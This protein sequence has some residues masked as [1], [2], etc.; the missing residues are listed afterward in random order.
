MNMKYNTVDNGAAKRQGLSRQRPLARAI[1]PR[2][3]APLGSALCA[4]LLMAGCAVT[5]E[6]MTDAEIREQATKDLANMFPPQEIIDEALD[7]EE[8]VARAIRYNL[9]YRLTLMESALRNRQLDLVRYDMLPR[10]A[11]NAGWTNRTEDYLT[12]SR[13][14]VT[15]TVSPAPSESLDRN[16]R[17]ADLGLS[18]N[19]LDFGV[20]YYQAQQNADKVLI[21]QE[22]RRKVINQIV[23][24][25]RAAFWRAATAESLMKEVSPLLDEVKSAQRDARK[26]EERRLSP[27][28]EILRYQKS[29]AGLTREFEAIEQDM[30]MA[31]TELAALMGLPPGTDFELSVP[32]ADEL[33]PPQVGLAIEEMESLALFNR[34]EIREEMYQSRITA[35]EAKKAMLKM[36]PGITFTTSANYDSNS[37]LV[38]NDWAEAGM[39]VSW[40]LLN[41]IS[42]PASKRMV[43]A[44]QQ[45]DE[46]RRLAL[47]IATLTQ[48]HLGYQQ[49]VQAH[50]NYLQSREINRIEKRLYEHMQNA[51]DSQSLSQLERIRAKMSAIYADMEMYQSYARMQGA[52]ANLYVS[53]G[54]DLLPEVSSNE[55]LQSIENNVRHAFESWR[56]GQISV[57]LMIKS[58]EYELQNKGDQT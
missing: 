50:H 46:M 21:A 29:L 41:L 55:D 40:N 9:D 12:M 44:Q 30:V 14:T 16:R 4:M 5:P 13:N 33:R 28:P 53:M 11:F 36:L 47:G 26:V 52:V 20:S 25:V 6:P 54:V 45:V 1:R 32:A 51:A 22:R 56:M 37:Y 8:V 48:V 17:T 23:Q 3:A 19:V 38:H 7:L 57:P 49:F 43:E 31:K 10:L 34:P 2:F 58:M 35:K 27:L 39:R 24:Q 42:G 15:G 18:W